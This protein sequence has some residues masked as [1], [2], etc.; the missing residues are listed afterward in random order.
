MFGS[1][2]V[3]DFQCLE[4]FRRQDSEFRPGGRSFAGRR[5]EGGGSALIVVLWVLVI[6]SLLVGSLAFNM[7]I[8]ARV[9]SYY[10]KRLRAQHL[11]RSGVEL[12]RILL[13]KS[14]RVKDNTEEEKAA[15]E[16]G[17]LRMSILHLSRGLGVRGLQRKLAS[18]TI[19]LDI[20][21][22]EGRRNVN[23]LSD[24]DWEE[25]L[26]QANVPSEKWDELIDCF[27]DW[28]DQND[29]H[30]LNGAESDDPFYRER[31]YE[32]KNAPLDTVDELL[33]IKG[34][35]ARIVYGGP[36][37]EEGEDPLLG[38]AQWLTVWGD[39][40][41]NV[42]TADREVL[43]TLPDVDEYAVDA[44][45]E[46]RKGEDGEEGTEDDGYKDINDVIAAAG[47]PETLRDRICVRSRKYLRVVSFGK[48]G[49]VGSGVW[50]VLEVDGETVRAVFW[51]EESM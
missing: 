45:I 51:R 48:V 2:G 29:E 5:R 1:F 7:E 37:M 12:A 14:S 6:L 8:E 47:L 31:G 26:D 41:V 13:V 4:V 9:A 39:G 32:C 19:E 50:C 21:P 22:E 17:G 25:I 44:I 10:R 30:R 40:R 34:F 18:G 35:D 42:N 27:R 24:D 49:E 36:P 46:G 38:I 11:A 15:A 16:A 33:L 3:G 43:L 23:M 20:L 28:V